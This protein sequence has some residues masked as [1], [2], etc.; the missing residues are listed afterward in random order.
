M[1]L[2][3]IAWVTGVSVLMF[4]LRLFVKRSNITAATA[5]IALFLQIFIRPMMFF[6]G[7]DM[8]YPYEFF[9]GHDWELVTVGILF[10]TVW[11]VLFSVIH[12]I[13]LRPL[14]PFGPL[15]P[16][17]HVQIN[18]KV[19][20]AAAVFTTFLGVIL[21]GNFVLNAKSISNFMF[22]VKVEK[23]FVGL[24]VIREISVIG[25]IFSILAILYYEKNVRILNKKKRIMV[26][27]TVTLFV[28]NLA[29]NYFWGNRYNIAMLFI[30]LGIGW[31]FYI[32]R[33]KLFRLIVI[34]IALASVLQGLKIVRNE[35]FS[36]AI[37]SDIKISH[38]FWL[39]ISTS[40]HFS[41]FDA[42]ILAYRDAGDRFPFREGKDFINGLLAWIPRKFYPKKETYCMGGWF[43]R[44]YE[45][46]KVNGWPA[47]T[48][49]SWYVNFGI[50][51]IV[52]GSI[53]SGVIASLF[54]ASYR[55]VK[56]SYWQAAIAPSLA[57]LMFDGGVD[58]GFVQNIVTVI[59]PL[60]LLSLV[61][62]MTGRINLS[63]F[64]SRASNVF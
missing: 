63:K 5:L 38:S 62:G 41:E 51:G 50:F 48:I 3:I 10:A 30:S 29:F 55:I 21:T 25:A 53:L 18:S 24:Y 9:G 8:P 7:L 37:G 44:V 35:A 11:I 40:L 14:I 17:A 36:N 54:D 57:F 28:L 32:K 56:K 22:Q 16:Q 34:I 31:H 58:T 23:A 26:Y 43:R 12:L 52:F 6:C 27:L 4:M 13:F 46:E 61:L 19:L 2:A 64:N 20:F 15:L 33:I 49:G 1:L 47:T 60:Y 42:F 39:S 45:P 59:M